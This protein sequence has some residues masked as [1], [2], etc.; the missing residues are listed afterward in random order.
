[1]VGTMIGTKIHK[2]VGLNLFQGTKKLKMASLK[3]SLRDYRR[4][5][6][7]NRLDRIANKPDN[8]SALSFASPFGRR[9]NESN[10]RKLPAYHGF[11]AFI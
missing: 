10:R 1:M 3:E 4:D 5:L 2:Q 6:S 7:N 8:R 11:Q 9:G